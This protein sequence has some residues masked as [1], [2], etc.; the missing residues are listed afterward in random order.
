MQALI[1]RFIVKFNTYIDIVGM[2]SGV[3]II[4]INAGIDSRFK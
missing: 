3:R 4:V 2:L 1:K